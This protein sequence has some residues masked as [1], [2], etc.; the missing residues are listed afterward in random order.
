MGRTFILLLS[1]LMAVSVLAQS[2]RGA[3]TGRILD[4]SGAAVPGASVSARSQATGVQYRTNSTAAGNYVIP[5]LPFGRYEV[6]VEAPGF[7]RFVQ[8]EVEV[9]VAQTVTLNVT[10][11]V[12]QVEQAV[13]V[14][15][16][17][18]MVDASTSDIGTTVN[19]ERILDLPLQIAANMRSPEA[20]IFLAPGVTG[21]TRDTQINGSQSRAK[22]V[23]LDG[24]GSTS[25]ESGGIL[26][27]YPS[28]EAIGEFKLL[29]SNFNAEFGRTGGGFEIFTTRSGGNDFHGSA[30]E[31]FRNDALD[32]RGFFARSTPVNRQNE[33]GAALGGPILF[34]KMYNGRN[35][36]FFHFVYSGFRYRAGA[37]NELLSIPSEDLRRG[38]F[39][40]IGRPVYDPRT[41]RT[42][43]GRTVRDP[44]AGNLIPA[45]R[46]SNVAK[47][48]VALLPPTTNSALLNNFLSVG[49]QRF[50]RD[51]VNVKIDHNFSE[52]NRVNGFVYIGT[53]NNIDPERLPNPFTSSLNRDYRSRWA[54]L[55]HDYIF[56]PNILNNFRIGFTRE[57]EYWRK[58]SVGQGWPEK[59]GLK[60]VATGDQ[61]AF[62]R[63]TFTD[64]FSTWADDSKSYGSQVNN[65]WQINDSLSYIRGKHALKMGVEGRWLQTNGADFFLSQGS[66]SFTSLETGLP[67]TATSGNAFASFLLGAVNR[68]EMNI[69]AVV[70]GNRYRYFASFI[71]DDWK[72]TRKLTLN[73]GFRYEIYFPRTEA[74]GNLSGFDPTIPNPKA[75]NILG[76]IAFLGNGPGR[77][78]R[79]SFA[80]TYYKNFG[81]RFGF[82]YAIDPKTVLRG[83]YGIFYAPGNATTGLRTSQSFGFGF[84]VRTTPATLDNGV[85]P[86]FALDDGIPQNFARPPVIDPSVSNGNDVNM[87]GRTDGRPP[88]FQNWSFGLQRELPGRFRVEATYV[89]NKGTRLGTGLFQINEV[90]PR[91]LTLGALLTRPAT[92]PEAAAAGIRIPYPGFTSSV[93]QALRPYPQFNNIENRSNP[94]GNSTYHALQLAA[95]KR[96]SRG[97][98]LL[99]NYT[100]SKTISDADVQAGGG[101]RGQTFYNR[102]LEK[103]ISIN[104]VPHI[105]NLSYV[106]ELPFGRGKRFLNRAGVANAVA[107]GWSF[108]GIHQYQ[109]GKPVV[110]TATNTLPLFNSVLRPDV[111]AGVERHVSIPDFDPARDRWINPAAFAIPGA[112]RFG[113]SAR[114]HSDVRAPAL[115][116]ESFGVIKRTPLAERFTLIFRAEYFNVFNRTQFSAPAAVINNANFGRISGQANSPRQGQLALRLEF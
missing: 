101:T 114:S 56:S 48:A 95:D 39:T 14:T 109:K 6:A 54:R 60:G 81:P 78:G 67:G 66:F 2:D 86:A 22:E 80:D 110:L 62:P 83:G 42:E 113:A 115:L 13:E 38:D 30:F 63:V 84:N 4:P 106:Y 55:N 69:L 17:V 94:N 70:P 88:Y 49:A 90:D 74:H 46:F 50:T 44:F 23:L 52:K 32:A 41:T 12:G 77:N 33:F 104:D 64:G 72:A 34:P 65:T 25:P 82:A 102:R 28:V 53:Q 103:A 15:A 31:Y 108:T 18:G 51:Q 76:A 26:F 112:L 79:K 111:V 36:S 85:T 105:V 96:L 59:L 3:I 100:F 27:T 1:S 107:G 97:L 116:N 37:T 40:R 89:G 9:N 87:I 45:A 57:G 11:E 35:R 29:T 92:S 16:A 75:G 93:A 19:R 21:N 68:A 73:V 47:N 7:R 5:Q 71:Q 61:G 58:L 20:F 91:Y 99:A 43:G 10:L 24:I 98:T 8:K